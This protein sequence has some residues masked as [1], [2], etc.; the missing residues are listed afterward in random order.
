MFSKDVVS[1]LGRSSVVRAMFEEGTRLKKIYGEDKVYDFS[2]GNPDVEPPQKVKD[3]LNEFSCD[4]VKGRHKYMNNAGYLET[5]QAIATAINR[6]HHT[7]L[8]VDHVCMTCG[9]AGGLN[10]I[11]KSLLNP[12]E[13]V[14]IF[15]PYFVEY[16]F[17]IQNFNGVPVIVETNDAF[18]IDVALLA[19]KINPKT[20]AI[21]INSPNNPTGVVYSKE[22]LS[23]INEM[24]LQKQIEYGTEIYI[25]SDEPYVKISYGVEIPSVFQ[26]FQ[27]SI[28]VNSFSKSLALPGERIGYIALNPKIQQV[29]VL[30]DAILFCNRTLGYVNAPAIAQRLITALID[31]SVDVEAYREKRDILY[32]GLTKLGFTCNRPDGAFYLF[33]KS[34]IPDETVFVKNALENY[35]IIAAPGGGF[36]RKGYFRL[37]Y[38]V[39]KDVIVN[40]LPSFEKLAREYFGG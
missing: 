17:Y 11:L 27:N 16:L 40:A 3:I 23:E 13:E 32:N 9:A 5:R 21:L 2:I 10:V 12:E 26:I 6:T 24:L 18:D 35:Q 25:L 1:N 34:P 30:M 4:T 29:D 19:S 8:T 7:E 28:I 38:C 20:K 37:A 22:K 15:A 39:S 14:I 33:V 31:E 36:G